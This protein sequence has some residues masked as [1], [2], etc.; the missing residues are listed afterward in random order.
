VSGAAPASGERLT[1]FCR[2]CE[3]EENATYRHDRYRAR[4]FVGNSFSPSC[5]RG[6]ACLTLTVEWL[7]EI[8]LEITREQLI[9]DPRPALLAAGSRQLAADLEP[10]PL[11]SPGNLAGWQAR[12]LSD[13]RAWGWLHER[14]LEGETIE[15]YELGF[16]GRAFTIPIRDE[17]GELVNLRRRY[18]SPAA[19]APKMTGLRGRGSHL[20]PLSALAAPQ[21]DTL[22]LCE[23]ELDALLLNQLEIPAVT[24]CRC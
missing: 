12:L 5:P 15:Q 22:V 3:H 4:W 24:F 17:R 8:G 7:A 20:Y 11:P 13:D 16:D 2:A 21:T 14:A 19:G 9:E 18:L 6:A 10:E 23:G 1:Y